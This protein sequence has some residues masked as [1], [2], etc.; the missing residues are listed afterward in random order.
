MIGEPIYVPQFSGSK[1]RQVEKRDS[2]QYVPLLLTLKALLHDTSIQEQLQKLPECIHQNG[3]I[4]DFCDGA[5]F[6]SHPLFSKD[7]HALQV[8]A[9]YDELEVCNPLGSHVKKH[10]VGVV[11][12]TLGNIHYKYRS[13]LK[14]LQLAI[15]A[16]IPV[17]EKHGLHTILKPLIHDLNIL[18]TTGIDVNID[19]VL[20]SYKGALLAML[21]DNLASNDLGGFKKSFSFAFRC[22]R[23]CLVTKDTM[24]TNFF[25]EAY[26]S[27]NDK[28][29]F[30]DLK[31]LECDASDHFS[32]IYGINKR[33]S[34][35]D[36]KYFSIFEG[37]L[38]HDFMHD[39][40]E[41]L[42]PHEIRLMLMY[43]VSSNIFTLKEFNDRLLNFNFGYSEK[44]KP[45]PIYSTALKPDKMLRSSASQMLLLVQIL[46]LL[47]ADKIPENEDH[48]GCFILLRQIFD[49]MLAPIVTENTCSSLKLLIRDHHTKFIRLYGSSSYIPKMHFL[50]HYP[51]QM[52]NLGSATRTWTM[53]YEAKLNFFKQSSHI[54]N[55]KNI[56]FSLA[57]SHQ[58]WICYE[59]ASGCLISD[60]LE[61][62]PSGSIGLVQNEN[63]NLQQSL[64]LEIPQLS[65][66]ATICRPTWVKING[67]LYKLNNSYLVVDKDG[68]DPVFGHLHD[69]L[70]VSNSLVVFQVIK[71]ETLFFEAHYHAYA[72][73]PT[74]EQLLYTKLLCYD[75]HHAHTLNNGYS[76]V[77]LKHKL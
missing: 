33:S 5:R 25:S 16:S 19:G 64:Q 14:L 50:I 31:K 51:E 70:I 63:K 46:P 23:T 8:I 40:L 10:K 15:V 9:H 18:A 1:R 45:L 73:K 22:C 67:I 3:K 13:K 75:V 7:P 57:N 32:K 52:L 58:R 54:S 66:E 2:Y 65:L 24:S 17:I 47:I 59:M 21:A 72:I 30:Q 76:Y 29:H 4:E 11:T 69:I 26:E 74:S 71:C 49:L 48:W 60:S 37:G 38:P 12:Y 55:F 35:I 20:K 56:A 44:D 43:F 42:A 27:R 77:S 28:K 41:G 53:R 34:L 6:K 61:C 62:G 39:A 36:V 68:L